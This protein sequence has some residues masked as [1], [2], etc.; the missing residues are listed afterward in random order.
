MAKK[1]TPKATIKEITNAIIDLYQKVNSL[2]NHSRN[3]ETTIMSYITFKND[4]HK[5]N[6]WLKEQIKKQEK[7]KKDERRDTKDDRRAET[8]QESG[9]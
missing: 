8:H 2:I 1:K 5:Y 7:G 3:M 9:V 4:T 6:E